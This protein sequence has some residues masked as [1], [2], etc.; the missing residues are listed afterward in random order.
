MAHKNYMIDG[1]QSIYSATS[2]HKIV[3]IIVIFRTVDALSRSKPQK[4]P[5]LH[6]RPDWTDK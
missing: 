4:Y 1:K 2:T 6:S 5:S 3:D